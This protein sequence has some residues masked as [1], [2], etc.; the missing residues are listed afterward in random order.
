MAKI[1]PLRGTSNKIFSISA[2]FNQ[3]IDKRT[4]DDVSSDQ[5]FFELTNFYNASEGYLSKRPGV[6][7]SN[8]GEFIKKLATDDY[9]PT[10]YIIGTN[11]FGETPEVLKARILDIYN[12][13]F[14]GIKKEGT[15][16]DGVKFTFQA[17][18]IVGF[19]LLKN[20]FFLEAMQDFETILDGDMSEEVRSRNVEFACIMIVGGFYT[21]VQNDVESNRKPGLYVCRLE[22]RIKYN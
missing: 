6:Y 3:G 7:N 2:N 21:I 20:T 11:K 18:K 12:T 14:K 10:K 13:V 22:T 16:T 17:D 4:A 5:S 9:D 15:E 1:Q 19:Q 8:I